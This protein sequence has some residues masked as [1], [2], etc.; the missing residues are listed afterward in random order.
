MIAVIDGRGAFRYRGTGI[1]TYTT[2]LI[3]GLAATREP[4][5]TLVVL[6]PREAEPL[7]AEDAG[8]DGGGRGG[9]HYWRLAS[10]G[11][12]AEER[13]IAEL[14]RQGGADVLHMPQ[15]GRGMPAVDC[16]VV[17]TIHDLIP[18]LLPQTCSASYLSDCLEQLPWIVQRSERLIAVS[19]HTAACLIEVLGVPPDKVAVIYE[20]APAA[21]G[22]RADQAEIVAAGAALGLPRSYIL[23]TG[24][25]SR[26]KNLP[27]LLTALAELGNGQAPGGERVPGL[28]LTGR[29]GPERRRL[30][31]LG[32]DLGLGPARLVT[33]GLVAEEVLPL[34]YQGALAV[35]C[36]SLHEGFG[37]PLVEAMAAGVA[38][39][40]SD[41][42]AHREIAGPAAAY[43]D[44]YRPETLT[45]V[46]GEV[47]WSPDRRSALCTWASER[48]ARYSWLRAARET[49]LTYRWACEVR[50]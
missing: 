17:T 13:E 44:P 50:E 2:C 40:A 36:P 3:E 27:A 24:G 29:D 22:R 18:L 19:R 15:N 20:A 47:L 37:L 12:D 41:I 25:L 16:A 43:F 34:V 42:P 10:L 9:M 39:V 8:S 35:V 1:G 26:R 45:R 7:P 48:L 5:D 46:L 21:F 32:R 14:C 6:I 38:L 28:V 30:V 4:D 33:P 23:H 31:R 49:W 11:R